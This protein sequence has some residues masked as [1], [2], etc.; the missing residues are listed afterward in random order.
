MHYVLD[1]CFLHKIYMLCYVMLY[2]TV[3][4]D[5]KILI[6]IGHILVIVLV[7][8]NFITLKILYMFVCMCEMGIFR[9]G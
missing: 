6:A 5:S 4:V 3:L 8:F 7:I 1:L 9:G 2:S